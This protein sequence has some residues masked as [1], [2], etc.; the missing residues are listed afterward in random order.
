[1]VNPKN[2]KEHVEVLDSCEKHVGTVDAI[3]GNSIKLTKNDPEAGGEHHYIPLD[4]VASV[5]KVVRLMKSFDE[6]KQEWQ[7]TPIA[8]AG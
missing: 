8:A 4:W 6:V 1:M 2:I 3:E 5:G 7:T